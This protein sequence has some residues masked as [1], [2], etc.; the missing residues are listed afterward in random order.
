MG[1]RRK[2]YVTGGRDDVRVPFLEVELDPP[3]EPLRLCH[4]SGPGGG[5]RVGLEPIRAGWIPGRGD[6]A[7]HPGRGATLRD[8]GRASDRAGRPAAEP[9]PGPGADRPRLRAAPGRTVTQMHYARRGEITPEMEFVAIREG[10]DPEVVR[11]EV[12]RGRAIIPAN[13]NHPESEPMIIGSRFLTKVN[14]NI[15]TS[16]VTSSAAE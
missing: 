16:A 12:A 10:V 15:G 14:A 2:V 5:P 13:V 1:I 6:V 3:N 9:F 4:R 8:E 7:P 11:D